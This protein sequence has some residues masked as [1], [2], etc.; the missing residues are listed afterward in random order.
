MPRH[1]EKQ[2]RE[3]IGVVAD[4]MGLGDWRL[5]VKFDT[6]ENNAEVTIENPEA[7]QASIRVNREMLG[8]EREELR[9]TV[10]HELMHCVLSAYANMAE[11]VIQSTIHGEM[12]SM[13]RHLLIIR[14]EEV[15][16]WFSRV[17]GP[18]LPLIAKA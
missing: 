8:A 16:H 17:M 5:Y 6:F 10:S 15:T 18:H 1:T 11:G 9:R 3:Y 12:G 7:R 2:I 14:E 4:A 13:I